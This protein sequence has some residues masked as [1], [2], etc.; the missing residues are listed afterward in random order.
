MHYF[1]IR[2]QSNGV[3][4][5]HTESHTSNN[6]L[7][8]HTRSF[9]ENDTSITAPQK[10]KNTRLCHRTQFQYFLYY[11]FFSLNSDKVTIATDL[12]NYPEV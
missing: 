3:K 1:P 12:G 6:R 8:P 4:W 10:T 2:R 7:L 11:D 9:S 5:G